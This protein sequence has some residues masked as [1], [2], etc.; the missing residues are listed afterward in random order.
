MQEAKGYLAGEI[1]LLEEE[2][3]DLDRN[4]ELAMQRALQDLLKRMHR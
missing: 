4:T 3:Y 2:T 1:E